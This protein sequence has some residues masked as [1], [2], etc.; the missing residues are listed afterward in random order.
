MPERTL[1]IENGRVVGVASGYSQAERG[2][3]GID[4]KSQ[5]VMPG[6][7]DSDTHITGASKKAG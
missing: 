3:Q 2:D 4:L 6:W 1:V 7:I 5:Y